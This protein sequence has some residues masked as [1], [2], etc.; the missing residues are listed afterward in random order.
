MNFRRAVF[1]YERYKFFISWNLEILSE[2]FLFFRENQ[3][4]NRL[5]IT[6]WECQ[7]IFELTIPEK[8]F[9][10]SIRLFHLLMTQISFINLLTCLRTV[11]EKKNYSSN[12]GWVGTCNIF[13]NQRWLFDWKCDFQ[14]SMHLFRCVT[15]SITVKIPSLPWSTARLIKLKSFI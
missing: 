7:D 15:Q 11:H 4:P 12:D 13:S 8:L 5:M 10:T 3:N 14:R 6:I 1:S 9:R 2:L